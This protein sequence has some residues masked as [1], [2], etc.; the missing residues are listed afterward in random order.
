MTYVTAHLESKKEVN[1]KADDLLVRVYEEGELPKAPNSTKSIMMR[2]YRL[3]G[4][5][6]MLRIAEGYIAGSVVDGYES[7]LA[8]WTNLGWQH[9][10]HYNTKLA[11][12]DQEIKQ[13]NDLMNDLIKLAEKIT[14]E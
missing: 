1:I 14:S 13:Q 2:I 5:M 7:R 11:D 4:A 3:N 12:K 6:V 8:L 10:I 9:V